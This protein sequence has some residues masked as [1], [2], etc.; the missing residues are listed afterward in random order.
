MSQQSELCVFRCVASAAHFFIIEMGKIKMQAIKCEICNSIDVVNDGDC[1]VCQ[2]S[3]TKYTVE[4]A[5]N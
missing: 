1:F 3:G 5:K 2:S 4:A